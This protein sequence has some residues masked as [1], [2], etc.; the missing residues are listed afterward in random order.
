MSGALVSLVSKGVQDAYIINNDSESSFFKS[1]FTRYTNFAQAPR[2]LD[3]TGV[4]QNS[5][6]TSVFLTSYGD[7]INQVW[8]EGSNVVGNIVGSTFELYIGGQIIDTQTFDFMADV[9]QV[10]MAE[11]YSKCQ[12]IN[13]NVSQSNMNFFPLHFF[14]CDNHMFLPLLALQYHQVEIRIHWGPS[15]QSVSNLIAYGNYIFLDTVERERFSQKQHD[16]LIT[17]VQTISGSTGSVDLS[18]LNHPVKSLYFGYPQTSNLNQ[19][20]TFTNASIVL[21]GNYLLENMSPT[22]FHTV[23]GYYHTEYGIINFDTTRMSPT[24]TQYYTYN[25]CLDATS[26]KP[27]GTCNFSRLDNGKLQIVGAS[28]GQALTTV[29]VYAVNYNVLRIK[30]GI[31]GVL[32]SN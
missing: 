22:Y 6:T 17:Q 29:T 7:L 20:W 2:Q 8:L 9:W 28:S 23:Q 21:N 18:L 31:A 32:F 11:T 26:Y 24:Y 14:F 5:G 16:F 1:K 27:T 10:Y 19:Y 4:V 30:S 13:N 12:T 3:F 25:F 15:I